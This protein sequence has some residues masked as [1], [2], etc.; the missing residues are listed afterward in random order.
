MTKR[1]HRPPSRREGH[2]WSALIAFVGAALLGANAG[3]ILN[4][5]RGEEIA[6]FTLHVCAGVL[7]TLGL[8]Q[9][10]RGSSS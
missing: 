6:A 5:T 8:V 1:I 3:V 4:E 7:F 2:L 10:W 9:L